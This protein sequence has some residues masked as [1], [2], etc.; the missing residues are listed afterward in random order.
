MTPELPW[1]G[2]CNCGAVRYCVVRTPLT[3]YICHCH[4]CQKRSGSAFSQSMVFPYDAVEFTAG[5]PQ[6]TERV[7][8]D[9]ARSTLYM[10]G[11]CYSRIYTRWKARPGLN[12]RASTLDETDWVRPV[13]QF[14]TSSAQAWA[15]VPGILSYAEQPKA[16]DYADMLD[17]WKR[18]AGA[19]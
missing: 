17:A 15:I 9:G 7:S 11:A 6:C 10:C 1:V 16:S 13:A 4:L 2:G 5:D 3:V 14:W 12:L 19:D 8:A 18:S